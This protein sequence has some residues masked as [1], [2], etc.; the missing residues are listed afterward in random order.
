MNI[1][2]YT[3]NGDKLYLTLNKNQFNKLKKDVIKTN[4]DG[5]LTLKNGDIIE[6]YN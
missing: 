5:S 2:V 4:Y 6:L 1:K 3:K